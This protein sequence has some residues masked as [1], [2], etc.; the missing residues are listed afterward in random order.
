V[1]L[2]WRS[3][4]LEWR[5]EMRLCLTGTISRL[6]IMAFENR[7]Q[8]GVRR[9]QKY[10]LILFHLRP[11]WRIKSLSFSDWKLLSTHQSY[12]GQLD[13]IHDW[14]KLNRVALHLH[15]LTQWEIPR[16][17]WWSK[18]FNVLWSG[19]SGCPWISSLSCGLDS[20]TFDTPATKPRPMSKHWR[21]GKRFSVRMKKFMFT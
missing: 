21:H 14:F 8:L 2:S 12:D 7:W 6:T 10:D 18:D 20:H 9:D 16:K 5:T 11:I 19:F 13:E 1:S 4:D 15:S 17:E 3:L